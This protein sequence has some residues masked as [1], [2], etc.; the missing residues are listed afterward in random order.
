MTAHPA[1]HTAHLTAHHKPLIIH[2]T[3]TPHAFSCA[4]MREARFTYTPPL[5][6][7]PR[8]SIL[9]HMY[10]HGVRS[11]GRVQS[12][13]YVWSMCAV[14]CAVCAVGAFLRA[15]AGFFIPSFKRKER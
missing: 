14:R 8:T 5:A 9:A 11:V 6:C 3:H 7:F 4:Y 12:S 15:R 10:M 1:H 13:T 2:N